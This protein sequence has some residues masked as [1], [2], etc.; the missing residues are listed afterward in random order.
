MRPNGHF[1]EGHQAVYLDVLVFLSIQAHPVTVRIHHV[2]GGRGVD[3]HG[4]YVGLRIAAYHLEEHSRRPAGRDHHVANVA[5]GHSAVAPDLL[6]VHLVGPRCDRL[7]GHGAIDVG[8]L[9]VSSVQP[10]PVPVRV[11]LPGGSGGHGRHLDDARSE[12]EYGQAL[13][14]D[15]GFDG[16][17]IAS[18]E[19]DRRQQEPEKRPW[20]R[21]DGPAGYRSTIIGAEKHLPLL[22]HW[23]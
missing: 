7:E 17:P 13:L 15:G 3:G 20:A 12:V 21:R 1:L 4:P 14:R 11:D 19:Q 16:V 9:M 5:V 8:V 6:Q 18:Q 2:P 22:I 10:D 23:E